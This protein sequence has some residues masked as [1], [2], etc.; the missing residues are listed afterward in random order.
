MEGFNTWLLAMARGVGRM[1][2]VKRCAV[3]MNGWSTS[4]F[5]GE[6]RKWEVVVG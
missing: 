2:G 5:D 3:K 4:A 6:N 1:R